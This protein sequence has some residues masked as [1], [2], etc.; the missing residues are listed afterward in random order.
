MPARQLALDLP[1][2]AAMSRA[3]FITG[4][5]NR[6]AIAA[7]DRWPDWPE[8]GLLV[9]GPPGSGKTHLVEIW[10]NA[11]RAGAISVAQL[12]W[13][14]PEALIARGA[15]AV[16]ELHLPR[17]DEAALFHLLNLAFE[18]RAAVLLTARELPRPRLADLA[19]RLRAAQPVELKAPDD[20]LLRRVLIKLFADRQL[21][22]DAAVVDYIALRIERSLDAANAIVARL[23]RDSLAAGRAVSRPLAAIAIADL[24]DRQP[25]FWPE[26]TG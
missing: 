22:V 1:H 14:E 26:E 9:T 16:E 11:S 15:I 23:D 19:S 6:A 3:D 8:R 18:R 25:D 5:A 21:A 4:D 20:D 13:I 24:F 7:I 2:R 12:P 10:R 17:Y